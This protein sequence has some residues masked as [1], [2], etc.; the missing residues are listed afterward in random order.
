MQFSFSMSDGKLTYEGR[1][2]AES[3]KSAILALIEMKGHGPIIEI[4][5]KA[6]R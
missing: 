1:L 5:V 6:G 2:R 4:S 3:L